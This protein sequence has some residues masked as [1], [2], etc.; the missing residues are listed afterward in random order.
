MSAVK[1]ILC[2]RRNPALAG[3]ISHPSNSL[4]SDAAL[5]VLPSRN[6]ALLSVPISR[7]ISRGRPIAGLC[8][9]PACSRTD[10]YLG[11]SPRAIERYI[12]ST[13]LSHTAH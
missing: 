5:A 9:S 1:A 8:P 11:T 6:L 10:Q 4:L 3:I 7:L 13:A 12:V 2:P